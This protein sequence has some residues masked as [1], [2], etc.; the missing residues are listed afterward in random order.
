MKSIP[1]LKGMY[2]PTADMRQACKPQMKNQTSVWEIL[3]E[4][5]WTIRVLMNKREM[6]VKEGF[7]KE[8]RLKEVFRSLMGLRN[9]ERERERKEGRASYGCVPS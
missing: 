4:M 3:N 1:L 6:Q 5:T 7:L 2:N 9:R 8:L